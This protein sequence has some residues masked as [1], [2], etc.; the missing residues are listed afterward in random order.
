[1]NSSNGISTCSSSACFFGSRFSAGLGCFCCL[2][3]GM[4]YP[5]GG[6]IDITVN[7]ILVLCLLAQIVVVYLF[8]KSQ[9]KIAK[10]LKE[11]RKAIK[12][13]YEKFWYTNIFKSKKSQ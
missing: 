10:I 3:F 2:D 5:Q 11:R 7:T 8:F 9:K 6:W 4:G 12:E 13:H 1:M